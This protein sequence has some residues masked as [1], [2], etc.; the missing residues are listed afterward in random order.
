MKPS[1]ENLKKRLLKEKRQSER[2]NSA[3]KIF[4]SL[5]PSSE[6]IGPILLID[7]SGGGLKFKSDKKI[8]RDTEINLKILLTNDSQPIITKGKITWYRES[9]LGNKKLNY[10]LGV[11]FYKMNRDDRVKFVTYICDNILNKYLSNKNKLKI[12]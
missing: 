11:E 1:L 12:S 8:K 5:P 10:V 7:I 4:Y 6:W 9:S 2:L 3:I